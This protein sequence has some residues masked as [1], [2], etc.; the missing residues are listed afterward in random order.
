VLLLHYAGAGAGAGAGAAAAWGAVQLAPIVAPVGA[1]QAVQSTAPPAAALVVTAPGDCIKF[2]AA[3]V[4][5]T[6]G[7]PAAPHCGAVVATITHPEHSALAAV[8]AAQIHEHPLF[9][10][11]APLLVVDMYLRTSVPPHESVTHSCLWL[12]LIL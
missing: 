11:T 6:A 7:V 8:A 12:Q 4:V 10:C 5:V 1:T 3:A 9:Q 2:A